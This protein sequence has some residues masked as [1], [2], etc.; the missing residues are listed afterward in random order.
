MLQFNEAIYG[1]PEI[2][3]VQRVLKSRWLS[4]HK[5]T[6]LFEDELARWWGRKYCVSTNSGSSANFIATQALQLPEG[7]EVIT[8]AGGAFP[9]TINPM[10]YLHLKP[11][12]VDIDLDTFCIDIDQATVT[13]KTRAVMFAHTLGRMPDMDRVMSFVKKYNLKFIEDCCDALASEQNGKRAG[14]YGDMATLSCYPAHLMTTGGEGGAI[15]TDDYSLYR[16][17]LMIRDWGR[18]C[19]CR[20]GGP[21]PACGNRFS[22]PKFDHRYYYIGLGLNFKLTEMQAAFGREQIKRLDGFVAKRKRNYKILYEATGMSKIDSGINPFCFPFLTKR[23]QEVMI[24]LFQAGI[25]VRT[26][27]SG[28]ILRHPAYRNL[29]YRVCGELKNSDRLFNESVFVGVGPHLTIK[30]MNYIV[31]TLKEIL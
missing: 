31:K 16:R 7:S 2:D 12:F 24:K 6:A 11:V 4:G 30:N 19:F 29:K 15:V 21:D 1:K 18:A 25:G 28:N 9:T 26:I 17:C 10:I 8:A 23:K 20:Y 27:F 14:T 22:N 3:A 13:N 5:E